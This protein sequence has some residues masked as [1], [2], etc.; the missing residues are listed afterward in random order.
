M[1]RTS[2]RFAFAFAIA[3]IAISGYGVAGVALRRTEHRTQTVTGSF[4]HVVVDAGAGD[5]TLRSGAGPAA[6]IRE[7]RRFTWRAPRLDVTV[8]GGVLRV[9]VACGPSCS[10]DLEIVLPRG[11]RAAAVDVSSGD[12]ML[13]GFAGERFMAHSD[14]GAVR[15][16][17]VR[18][19]VALSSDS[20]DV[21]ARD[22]AGDADLRTAS[23]DISATGLR[24]A[25]ATASS[26]SGDVRIALAS[27]PDTVGASSD[28]GDVAVAL[29]GG[30]YRVDAHT[31]SGSV[32]V[33]R[34]VRDE[35]APRRVEARTASGDVSVRGR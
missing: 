24:A 30:R 15:A 16:G 34:V 23:G 25:S 14:S 8:R 35:G 32:H 21:E 20:G 29:P 31:D 17:G 28:S 26:S 7:T 2:I 5:V 19:P 27:V 12:V 6:T 4:T 11:V 22:I 13:A 9:A 3:M 33:A 18:G 10:D 1:P